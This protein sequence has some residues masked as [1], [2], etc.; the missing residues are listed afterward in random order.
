MV[1]QVLDQVAKKHQSSISNVASKWVL[2][3]PGVASII[4]GARNADH[5]KVGMLMANI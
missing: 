1:W 5:V 2:D 4:L 3:K